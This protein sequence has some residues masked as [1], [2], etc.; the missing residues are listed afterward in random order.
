V[1]PLRRNSL[2]WFLVVVA[3]LNLP[4]CCQV[5]VVTYIPTKID[6]PGALPGST[7]VAES[8]NL[9]GDVV[10]V[11][12]DQ[13]GIHGFKYSNGAYTPIDFPAASGTYAYG[14]NDNG[15]VVGMASL[16]G[17]DRGFFVD[18]T[19]TFSLITLPN[20]SNCIVTEIDGIDDVGDIVGIYSGTLP[21]QA[22]LWNVITGGAVQNLPQASCLGVTAR[23]P[24][25]IDSNGTTIVGSMPGAGNGPCVGFTLDNL[26]G[27]TTYNYPGANG[28]TFN[29][30]NT[31]GDI[32]G[33]ANDVPNPG[34]VAS[35]PP[36]VFASS[37][38]TGGTWENVNFLGST[39]GPLS[40]NLALGNND[41]GQIVGV[42]ADSTGTFHGFVTDGTFV[43][44]GPLS[45]TSLAPGGSATATIT[46]RPPK[47]QSG[48]LPL[49]CTVA[50]AA[51]VGPICA[52]NPN[53]VILPA[54]TLPGTCVG[55]TTVL[56]IT[57]PG[58]SAA[59]KPPVGHSRTLSPAAQLFLQTTFLAGACLIGSFRR[60]VI[61]YFRLVL[62]SAVFL[63][64]LSCGGGSGS[65]GGGGGGGSGGT[66]PGTYTITV[67]A[68]SVTTQTTSVTVTVK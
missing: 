2:S 66:P 47:N 11:Y 14:I 27:L 57:I 16:L 50:P 9:S 53:P 58:A 37:S 21:A 26:L 62:L 25:G 7:T 55:T 18:A 19:G 43:L 40:L 68:P 31:W 36:F 23:T 1:S 60:K 29:G 49:L 39:P 17:G 41:W 45:T 35:S 12:Q 59:L 8:V 64:C 22:F 65:G 54:C 44:G 30:V 56:T 52:L 4:V 6:V 24:L 33:G 10:G 63:T 32:V 5:P 38:G 34:N 3:C 48:P 20:C 51:P 28:T 42:F 61:G 13:I 15:D 46:V 67:S